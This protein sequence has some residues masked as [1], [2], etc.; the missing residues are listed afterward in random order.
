VRT[1]SQR[2]RGRPVV[3]AVALA[4]W[5]A[6]GAV[7]V[8]GPQSPAVVTSEPIPL[9]RPG[10][11]VAADLAA[12]QT[13]RRSLSLAAGE[14][15]AIVVDQRGVDLTL[16]LT[17]PSGDPLVVVDGMD[18]E[19][20][21]ERLVSVAPVSGTYRLDVASAKPDG[22]GAYR[23]RV[24]AIRPAAAA[25]ITL[26]DAERA[27]TVAR[28]LR[29]PGKGATWPEALKGFETAL[30]RFTEAGDTVGVMKTTLELGITEN[31][32]SKPDALDRGRAAVR[33]AR[34]AGEQG[35][36]ARALRLVGNILVGRGDYPAGSE[37]LDEAWA[38]AAGLGARNSE[39]RGLN[40]AA[41]AYRRRGD[42]E[43]AVDLY[44]RAL[45]LARAT[46]DGQMEGLILNNLGVAYKTLG[47]LDRALELYE[48]ALAHRRAAGDTRSQ[49]HAL[50]NLAIVRRGRGEYEAARLHAEEALAISRSIG[51][52]VR[53]AGALNALGQALSASGRHAEALDWLGQALRL[54]RSLPNR[55]EE[56]IAL[57][58]IGRALRTLGR[59]DEAA[60]VLAEA[61]AE[62]RRVQSPLA[63]R[64]DLTELAALERDRG[65]LA[66]AARHL[67]AA[68]TLDET[69][70]SSI[71]SP[72][73]RASFVAAELDRYELYLD[74]LHRQHLAAPGAGLDAKA[75][76]VSERARA[77]VLLDGV[78]DGGVDVREGVP[79]ALL[80][81]EQ[82]LQKALNTA[83]SRLSAA[84]AEGAG[85]SATAIARQGEV[86]RL[87][88]DYARLQ[89]DIRRQ[90][91]GYADLVRPQPLAADR[92]QQEVLDDETVL[93]EFALGDTRSWL[94]AVTRD[95]LTLHALAGRGEIER[96]ARRWY[97]RLV[98]RQPRDGE[99]DAAYTRRVAAADRG[100]DRDGQAVS[101][102]LLGPIAAQLG[103]AWRGRRLAVVTA[104]V[105]DILPLNALPEPRSAGAAAT[106]AAPARRALLAAHH[107]IVRLPSAS[108]IA[109]LRRD[110]RTDPPTRM[111]AVLA[112]PVFERADPRVA[113]VE[114][115]PTTTLATAPALLSRNAL[116]RA[117]V[118]RLPFS[119][120]EA[121]AI[122]ALAP[123][124]GVF[125][126][127]GFEA[128]RDAALGRALRDYRIVHFATHG[129]FDSAR[130]AL[131]GLIFSLVDRRGGYRNGYVRLHDIYNLRLNA[132][133]VVLS[134][135]DTA[136]GTGIKGEGLVGLARAFMYA[137]AP[138]VV[139]S[140]WAVNDLATS[141]LMTRFYR[142]MLQRSL[143]PAAALHAA[144]REMQATT[145]WRD[146]YYWAGFTL[147]GDWR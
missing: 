32:L 117:R 34:E 92:I 59:F 133:L 119:R 73:L 4:V 98:A 112:D 6:G 120:D 13:D 129:V 44:E 11:E 111:L 53:E 107:E 3:A 69:V 46:A 100:R 75:L 29:D 5:A 139:A 33:L 86:E 81:E 99:D 128:T 122:A 93:L 105:L 90:S 132:E 130:P 82:R 35:A 89:T 71:T 23:L 40:D 146:P 22:R 102:A 9:L 108:V 140:L 16:T 80:A 17:M 134:A 54:S 115:V 49:Y 83:S 41:I 136:L 116:G 141:E 113:R 31:Y 7:P 52:G 47:E 72:E 91:P 50:I 15:V 77:R 19:Y 145:Q 65:D 58:A 84:L 123:T 21:P 43:H 144:Q 18:D 79:P 37:A 28:R 45:T 20:R 67:E 62:S 95:S 103:G 42:V 101:D 36:L 2:S 143:R 121:E 14:F 142:G 96:S 63:E 8:A 26:V 70:R 39:A 97:E 94:W 127:T 104:G 30:A 137:G 85:A 106:A 131:S 138:R 10:L 147:V 125:K 87:S 38:V 126:A 74:I 78:L 118:P 110:R 56:A 1:P 48:Q 66:A 109:A 135:C 114:P 76:H 61:L 12:G 25:D 55:D 60:T 57:T 68:L 24:V 124:A 88:A 64:D 51:D 27:F